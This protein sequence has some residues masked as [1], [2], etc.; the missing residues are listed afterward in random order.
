MIMRKTSLALL[1]SACWIAS[2]SADTAEERILEAA[3]VHDNVIATHL[4]GATNV[5]ET[6]PL[7]TGVALGDWVGML[8]AQ[9]VIGSHGGSLGSIIAVDQEKE[10]VALHL[11]GMGKSITVPI[12]LLAVEN[13]RVTAPTMSR[14]DVIA[15]TRTQ[16]HDYGY[17]NR[18]MAAM[19][20][21][22]PVTLMAAVESK[23]TNERLAQS[24]VGYT[25]QMALGE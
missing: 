2:A 11:N 24:E 8:E 20:G 21:S 19:T 7:P 4:S 15:M 5:A 9:T 22:A 10:L 3:R 16:S 18:V 13:G 6:A 23:P 17:G 12:E 25:Y 14:P 1:L